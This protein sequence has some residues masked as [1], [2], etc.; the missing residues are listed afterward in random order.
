MVR[1]D[2]ASG[3]AEI[4]TRETGIWDA[5]IYLHRM[6]GPHNV[7]IRGNWLLMRLWGWVADATVYLTL[8]LTASGVYL[9]ALL[10]AE[11]RAGLICLGSGALSFFLIV[12]ALY[13]LIAGL[14]ALVGLK[15]VKQVKAPERAIEQ[16]KQIPQAL[17]GRG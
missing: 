7:A 13:L 16:G 4:E 3:V 2:L 17:K 11:R 10:R 14:L 15:Q 1:V 12:F 5:M 8:F 6:P 9:W